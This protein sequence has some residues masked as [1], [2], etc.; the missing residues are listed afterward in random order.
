MRLGIDDVVGDRYRLLELLG[1]GG[2]GTVYAARDLRLEREVA[3]KLVASSHAEH[4]TRLKREF[5]SLA[6]IVHP[7]LVKLYE[8]FVGPDYSFIAME[9]VRGVDFA[10][11]CRSSDGPSLPNLAAATAQLLSALRAVHA[12]QRLHGDPKPSN[13]L[14]EGDGR[15]VVLDFGLAAEL[16]SAQA[17]AGSFSGTLDHVAPE[18]LWGLPLSPASD[19]YGVGVLLFQC[20]TGALPYDRRQLARGPSYPPSLPAVPDAC[21]P[22]LELAVQLLNPIA[23]RRAGPAEIAALLGDTAAPRAAEQRR[24]LVGRQKEL[25]QLGRAFERARAG[26]CVVVELVGDAGIGKTALAC[27]WL[28]S[29][30]AEHDTVVLHARCHPAELVPFNAIDEWVDALGEL[31]RAASPE[32]RAELVPRAP[33]ALAHVFPAA[34]AW[35][36]TDDEHPDATPIQAQELRRR[37]IAELRDTLRRLVTP[38]RPVVLWIDD[39]QWADRDSRRLLDELLRGPT[40]P[41][42]LVVLGSTTPAAGARAPEALG[43]VPEQIPLYGLGDDDVRRIIGG[44]HPGR[45]PEW[46]ERAVAESLGNPLLASEFARDLSRGERVEPAA[47]GAVFDALV[48]RR[49]ARQ[50]ATH[51]R[52]LELVALAGGSLSEVAAQ[53]AIGAEHAV[54]TVAAEL[55]AE[56]LLRLGPAD[57]GVSL[58]LA[59]ERFA[60]GIVARLSDAERAALHARLASALEATGDP[61]EDL[62]VDQALLAFGG[63][64]AAQVALRAAERAAESLAFHRAAELYQRAAELGAG[65]L[66]L[67]VVWERLACAQSD[68]GLVADAA[69]TTLRAADALRACEPGSPHLRR[70]SRDAASHFMR[71]GR[72]AQG[73]AALRRSLA[74]QGVY[75]PEKGWQAAA[76]IVLHR[77]RL[78]VQRGRARAAEPLDPAARE[79][80][81]T[82]WMAGACHSLFDSTRAA[83]FQVRH[84]TF[85]QRVRDPGHLAR[86][87]ATEALLPELGR[88]AARPAHGRGAAHRGEAL[89]RARRR[90][91]GRRALSHD[92]GGQRAPR[93]PPAL[94]ARA[95][96]SGRGAVPR[97]LHR[98]RLGARRLPPHATHCARGARRAARAARAQRGAPARGERPR[99]R[100]RA[101][102]AASGPDQRGLAVRRAG[103]GGAA[104]V[105]SDRGALRPEQQPGPVPGRVRASADRPVSATPRTCAGAPGRGVCALEGVVR[106]PLAERARGDAGDAGARLTVARAARAGA[107]R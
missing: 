55:E 57:R 86:A 97:A 73:L 19:W 29:V 85:A 32:R 75:Y 74:E 28:E 51:L 7:N 99:R 42:L 78:A 21:R 50:S 26:R 40:A 71:S 25:S 93:A 13:I 67:W 18:Q 98:C 68:A 96:R 77:A 79:R 101:R 84:A 69:E 105:R 31:V 88:R 52:L 17:A 1:S 33:R 4:M 91:Q 27:T 95:L 66:P 47:A 35:S 76:S 3:V 45:A 61:D 39:F 83:D 14:V 5:R 6:R 63:E 56:G 54:R 58:A 24:P 107:R 80:L 2:L 102:D 41:A 30:Q 87:L 60:E 46:L 81:D 12:A 16:V 44:G 9:R 15:V 100:E 82:Y 104:R 65:G 72:F 49:C 92:G 103:R 11:H 70:L 8:L 106:A 59:H 94:G 53:A 36:E 89:L 38:E 48:A 43:V 20:L 10:T 34:R 62:A 22:W 90:P 37:A 64:R 23:E